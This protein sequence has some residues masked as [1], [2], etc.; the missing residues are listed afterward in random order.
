MIEID[1][2]SAVRSCLCADV[3]LNEL[4][5]LVVIQHATG[6]GRDEKIGIFVVVVIADGA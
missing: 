1:E 3:G 2:C 4:S 6:F 5:L